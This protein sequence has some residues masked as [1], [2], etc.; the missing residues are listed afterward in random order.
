MARSATQTEFMAHTYLTFE[1]GSDEK[2]AQEA[3]H[4]LESLKAAFKLDKK[5]LYKFERKEEGAAPAVAAEPAKASDAKSKDSKAG[6]GA[7]KADP[8]PTKLASSGADIKLILRVALPNHERFTEQRLF[9]RISEDETLKSSSPKTIRQ[10]D[11]SFGDL[12][13]RFEELDGE[14]TGFRRQS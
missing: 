7:K 9:K 2:K 3:R 14:G 6:R 4:K 11:K 10:S 1:F 5:M 12:D 8:E 13:A